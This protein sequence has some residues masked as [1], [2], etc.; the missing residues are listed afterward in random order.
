MSRDI[1]S[2]KRGVLYERLHLQ[3]G[4]PIEGIGRSCLILFIVLLRSEPG[5][6]QRRLLQEEG[7]QLLQLHRTGRLSGR[8]PGK[9][10]SF[11]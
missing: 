2:D 6:S 9:A 10:K 1:V 7:A 8:L 11:A 4:V 3:L 5:R